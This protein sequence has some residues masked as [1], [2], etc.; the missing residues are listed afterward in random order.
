MA[1][2]RTMSPSRYARAIGF[3]GAV[4]AGDWIL[5]AGTSAMDSS[6]ATVGGDDP[7]AQA[8][9]VLRK[10]GV[11]LVGAG[12]DLSRVVHADLPHLRRPVGAGRAS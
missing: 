5:V 3:S 9:E 8:R 6:G 7:Y 12:G 1:V 10:V 4:R 2:S 11:A